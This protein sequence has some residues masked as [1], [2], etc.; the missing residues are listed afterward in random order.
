MGSVT[1]ARWRI[2]VVLL[3]SLAAIVGVA[4]RLVDVQIIQ[5]ARLSGLARQEINQEIHLAAQPWPYLR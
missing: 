3:V 1:I 5:Q 4:V 2:Y